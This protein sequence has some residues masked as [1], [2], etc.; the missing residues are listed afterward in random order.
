M[1]SVPRSKQ[2]VASAVNDAAREV[3]AALGIAIA[4]SILART[5]TTEI[6]PR[7]TAFPEEIRSAV[8]GSLANAITAANATGHHANV[9]AEFGK[10]HSLPPWTLRLSR[11]QYSPR[12]QR[13]SQDSGL[14]ATPRTSCQHSPG[15]SV[16]CHWNGMH[17]RLPPAGVFTY[18]LAGLRHG[19]SQKPEY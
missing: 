13:S 10:R 1:R 19:P 18:V 7:L 14:A 9:L 5:Y 16:S 6:T 15:A 17:P 12:S 2:G 8:S 4:G 3:G 11:W